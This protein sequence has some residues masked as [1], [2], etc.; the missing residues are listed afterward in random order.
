MND[1][2][3]EILKKTLRA[4]IFA[5][6]SLTLAAIPAIVANTAWLVGFSVPINAVLVIVKNAWDEFQQAGDIKDLL[7]L[8][9]K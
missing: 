3:K 5:V 1:K 9:Q 4:V 8:N 2:Q 7:T 6:I